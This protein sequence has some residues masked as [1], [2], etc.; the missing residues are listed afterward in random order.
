MSDWQ[1]FLKTECAKTYMQQT[2]DTV[3]Q[4]RSEG[5][6]VYPPEQYVFSAF[7]ATPLSNIKVVILGRSLPRRRTSTW[8]V[9]FG[10]TRGW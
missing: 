7:D 9:F 3:A 6:A 4:K 8:F 5:I 1:D 10:I 2:L